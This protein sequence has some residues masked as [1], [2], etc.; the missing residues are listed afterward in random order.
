MI[1]VFFGYFSTDMTREQCAQW[2]LFLPLG[3]TVPLSVLPSFLMSIRYNIAF[4]PLQSIAILNPLHRVWA[5]YTANRTLLIL[6]LLY[7]AAQTAAGLWQYTVPGST[8][9]PDL[10]NNYQYHFCVYLPPKKMHFSI[11]FVSMEVAFDC[12]VFLL[13]ASRTVYM[14]YHCQREF[15][16]SEWTTGLRF[17]RWTLLESLVKDGALYFA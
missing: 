10:V 12:L 6:L 8:P 3:V 11:M 16:Q 2:M 7:L 13:T 5:M 4:A 15:A 17:R 9:A 1:V 14:H